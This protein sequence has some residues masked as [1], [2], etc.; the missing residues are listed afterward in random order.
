MIH[1]L[2]DKYENMIQ[3]RDPF[4]DRAQ[5]ASALTIPFLVP[6]DGFNSATSSRTPNQG[7]GAH[8]VRTLASKIL[9]TLLPPNTPFFKFAVN[10]YKLQKEGLP[11]E[12]VGPQ[13]DEVL[14]N[15]EGE[16]MKEVELSKARLALEGALQHLIVAGN[17]LLFVPDNGAIKWYKL[18]NFVISRDAGGSIQQIITHDKVDIDTLDEDVKQLVL[19]GADLSEKDDDEDLDV[20][21]S[22][23]RINKNTFK[24]WQEIENVVI[25]G[26]V[27]EI[28]E[29]YLPFIPL[30]FSAISNEDYGRGLVEEYFGNFN[31]IESLSGLLNEGA[32]AMSKSLI[33]VDKASGMRP[34]VLANKDNLSIIS[35]RVRNGVA[36]D[37]GVVSIDK[38]QDYAFVLQYLNELKREISEAFLLHQTRDAERVTAEEIRMMANELESVLGGVYS[39]LAHEFQLPLLRALMKKMEKQGALPD[40]V[41]QLPE[42]VISP[43]IVAGLDALGRNSD[44][45][46]LLQLQQVLTPQEMQFINHGELLRRKLSYAGVPD[47]GLVKSQ[48]ELQQEAQQQQQML[49]QQQMQQLAEKAAPAVVKGVTDQANKG[50]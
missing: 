25:P 28:K 11:L 34:G 3:D 33:V 17:S 10:R 24:F 29:K 45:T 18:E 21:T 6:E 44:F 50:E 4:L 30:R 49:Q 5:T 32:I 8:A 39:I 48:Q 26:T 35:G 2:K 16:I 1:G 47:E 31:L 37:V 36:A 14:S 19:K 22:A 13:L 41:K 40:E 43:M 12:M 15:I 23:K 46:K 7:F 20:F 38:R 9:M 27:R 42:E